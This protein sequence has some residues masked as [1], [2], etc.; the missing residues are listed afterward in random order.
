MSPD[1]LLWTR[2]SFVNRTNPAT[3]DK[4]PVTLVKLRSRSFRYTSP[5]MPAM[6]PKSPD[7]RWQ[8]RLFKLTSEPSGWM[9][10]LIASQLFR[11]RCVNQ[12]H[13]P[14]IVTTERCVILALPRFAS[15]LT[16][17]YAMLSS[18]SQNRSMSLSPVSLVNTLA[19]LCVQA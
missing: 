12:M 6:S 5:A 4:S 15:T 17:V 8:R 7:A 9:S 1:T 11:S 14:L 13:R 10:P 18:S 16:V 19:L 2:A 3:L